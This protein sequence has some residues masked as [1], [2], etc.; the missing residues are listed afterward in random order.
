MLRGSWA[1]CLALMIPFL[2]PN[3]VDAQP[4]ANRSSRPR[5]GL[6]LAGGSARGLAHLGVLEWLS[7]HRVPV[8]CIAGTSM[9]G[10]VAGLYAAGF[11]PEEIREFLRGIDWNDT[12]RPGP[13]FRDLTFRRKE[14]RRDFPMQLEFGLKGGVTLPGGLSACHGIGLLLSRFTSPYPV[15]ASFD[16]LPTPF[17]SVAVDLRDGTEFVF[18][19]GNLF[20]ALRATM[21]IP[22]V[23]SPWIVGDRTFVDGGLLNNLPIDVMTAEEPGA[24][25]AV[26]VMR[27][28]DGAGSARG[29]SPVIPT[30]LET[31]SRATVLGSIERAETNRALADV[32]VT[33][34]VHDVSL[35]GFRNLD[36]VVEAGR[37]AAEK[38]LRNGGREALEQARK[39]RVAAS[40]AAGPVDASATPAQ[41]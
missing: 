27:R 11:E 38:A 24:V 25:I 34:D 10:L 33:P 15:L 17:R 18:R 41:R 30:I 21:A 1:R 28:L 9:G 35:R 20:D 36:R 16:E 13:A 31:L 23:F 22:G 12:L 6:A 37:L 7:E 14:D 8:D 29:G 40:T 5:V 39:R 32:L 19:D 3:S 26:D 2:I 4:A